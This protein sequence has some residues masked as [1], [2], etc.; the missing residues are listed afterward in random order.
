MGG[1]GEEELG[2]GRK[3]VQREMKG[4]R[5]ERSVGRREGG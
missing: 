1:E 3:R 4:R 2:G 5:G